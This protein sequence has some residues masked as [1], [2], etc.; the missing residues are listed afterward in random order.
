MKGRPGLAV[1]QQIPTHEQLGIAFA[2]T[3]AA[4]R[5]AVNGALADLKRRGVLDD[6]RRAWL[7]DV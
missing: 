5:D 6:L 1:V 2:K 3:N 7:M 4:L